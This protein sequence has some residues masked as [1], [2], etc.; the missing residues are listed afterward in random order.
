MLRRRD[1]LHIIYDGQCSFCVRSLNLVRRLARREVFQ[2]HD[3]NDT[4]AVLT[5][6]PA[7]ATADTQDAMVVVTHRGEIFRGFF[8][9]R[10]M[11][12]ASPWLYPVLLLF[13]FPG[14]SL[15]GRPIYAW[16]ARHRRRFGCAA[17]TCR[18]PEPI[19]PE[20]TSEP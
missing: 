3:A 1:S 14:A 17:E 2:F 12:W 10:R 15:V 20:R 11:M 5:H 4:S 19:S 18:L 9:F 7:L 6:F 8:A 16:V 13:Y